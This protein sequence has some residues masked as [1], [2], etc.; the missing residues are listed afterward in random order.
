[1]DLKELMIRVDRVEIG[2]LGVDGAMGTSFDEIENLVLDSVILAKEASDIYDIEVE[3]ADAP[4]LSVIENAGEFLF[5]FGTN[6]L[7]KDNMILAFGG[8]ATLEKWEAPVSE[9]I[10]ER[11][12]RITTREVDGYYRVIEI[13]RAMLATTMNGELKRGTAAGILFE[14]KAIAPIDGSGNPLSPLAIDL[15]AVPDA[16][17]DP[18]EDDSANTF[19]WTDTP[20]Y[21]GFAKYEYS[22]NGGT[23]FNNC[24][25]NPQTGLT[26][27]IATGDVQVRVRADVTGSL[28]RAGDVLVSTAPYT[29]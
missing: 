18:V 25:V 22:V 29:T 21:V 26:G 23:A 15:I 2:A 14:C 1:M 28:G 7:K 10:S 8:E 3:D 12:L 5:S 16:P 19:A 27:V 17:T 6:D 11:C 24:T 20:N 9:T 13:P 4:I